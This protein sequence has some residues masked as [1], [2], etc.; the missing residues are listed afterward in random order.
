MENIVRK[1][2][3]LGMLTALIIAV[4]GLIYRST[5]YWIIPVVDGEPYG[6]GDILDFGF[7]VLL[8][9]IAGF[10]LLLSLIEFF[11]WRKTSQLLSLKA[12]AISIVS[13]IG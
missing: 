5:V 4:L 1:T 11:F 10:T 6:L 13:V 3:K 2:V 8:I 9:L 7:A 12:S